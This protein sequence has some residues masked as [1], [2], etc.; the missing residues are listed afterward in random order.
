MK[1]TLSMKPLFKK[2][3]IAYSLFAMQGYAISQTL[4]PA[5]TF[6]QRVGN[7]SVK[8]NTTPPIPPE[9]QPINFSTSTTYLNF[10][11][12][13]ENSTKELS[14]LIQNTGS[15]AIQPQ[16]LTTGEFTS[17]HNCA[18]IAVGAF[19]AV[20]TTAQGIVGSNNGLLSITAG[21]ITK[22]INLSSDVSPYLVD[23][24][25][26]SP[27]IEFGTFYPGQAV[28]YSIV[29][30][31]TGET[32]LNTQFELN[33][34]FGDFTLMAEP[35][36]QALAVGDS[37]YMTVTPSNTL[38]DKQGNVIV[39]AGSASKQVSIHAN[40][41]S[42]PVV[43]FTLS[44]PNA[45]LPSTSVGAPVDVQVSL[46]NSGTVQ[47]SNI[48][49]V[50]S[51]QTPLNQHQA[52]SNCVNI[53]PGQTCLITITNN[54]TTAGAG[55]AV[56]SVETQN[57]LKTV[58][59]SSTTNDIQAQLTTPSSVFSN[60]DVGSSVYKTITVKNSGTYGNLTNIAATL[61]NVVNGLSIDE[62]TSTCSSASLAPNQTCNI[63]VKAT[64]SSAGAISGTVQIQS[65]ASN[66]TQSSAFTGNARVPTKI[67]QTTDTSGNL[68]SEVAFGTVSADTTKTFRIAN[69]SSA[70]SS[71]DVNDFVINT[72]FELVSINN[73]INGATCSMI[74]TTLVPGSSCDVTIKLN[75]VVGNYS[76]GYSLTFYS[77]ATSSAPIS[78][79]ATVQL[80]LT[81][82]VAAPSDPLWNSVNYLMHFDG[83][84]G[85][86]TFLNS[87]T[88]TN[89][90]VGA[91][92]PTLSTAAKYFGTSSL[93][94]TNSSY[95]TNAST[96]AQSFGTSSFT[97][98][99]YV[100]P[101][102]LQNGAIFGTA[103]T[104]ALAF[105]FC[106]TGGANLCVANQNRSSFLNVPHGISAGAWAHIALVRNGNTFTIYVNGVSKGSATSTTSFVA[107]NVYIGRDGSSY[108]NTYI[109][110]LRVTSAARYSANFTPPSTAF[111]NN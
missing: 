63:I 11:S 92:T 89:L 1:V 107:G 30:L 55:S 99:A 85:S 7:L 58:S 18:T 108:L 38:G 101:V 39:S 78:G 21:S 67:F 12:F 54:A 23:F 57:V 28:P 75:N 65:N 2:V 45:I 27:S 20:T 97:I 77:T 42:E 48:N 90:T 19:C 26:S 25:L 15:S 22:T 41:V 61:S 56:L 110:E 53:D 49:A 68:I 76:S 64:P 98:E 82:V 104:N 31:N 70:T 83:S 66:G 9:E 87:K 10:G 46:L 96:S 79:G 24:E 71:F 43:D 88:G 86:T 32:V 72:P 6:K 93:Y 13:K 59:I 16:I 33:A 102:T 36:C 44:S 111:P 69:S 34:V 95:I 4:S 105:Y 106:S 62:A 5:Y 3:V 60:V 109:D 47:I 100:K 50:L 17:T 52:I 84:N 81:G 51:S 37:C 94:L 103:T 40:V 8:S 73:S 91:S 35:K 74:T 80:P 14:V 29:V